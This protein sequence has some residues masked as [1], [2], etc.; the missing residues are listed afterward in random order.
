MGARSRLTPVI[1]VPGSRGRGSE[2]QGSLCYTASWRRSWAADS[3]SL[4]MCSLTS[5]LQHKGIL[6]QTL[7]DHTRRAKCKTRD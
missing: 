7:I 5:R 2:A 6:P 4:N 3:S 1:L